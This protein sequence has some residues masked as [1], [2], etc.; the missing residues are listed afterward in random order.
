V[1]QQ[2]AAAQLPDLHMADDP[3]WQRVAQAPDVLAV[4]HQPTV[5]VHYY[6]DAPSGRVVFVSAIDNLLRGAASHAIYNLNRACG[7]ADEAGLQPE[8]IHD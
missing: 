3:F 8:K 7:W 4:A 5:Q 2:G 6:L 1:Q